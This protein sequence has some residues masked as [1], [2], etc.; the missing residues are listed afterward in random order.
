M[1]YSLQDIYGRNHGKKGQY[2]MLLTSTFIIVPLWPPSNHL[3]NQAHYKISA[4]VNTKQME[5]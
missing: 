1:Y 3:G 2:K 5:F 4:I